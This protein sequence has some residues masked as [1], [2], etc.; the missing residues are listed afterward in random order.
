MTVLIGL[1][2]IIE[3]DVYKGH[4]RYVLSPLGNQVIQEL[5]ESYNNTLYSFC[6]QYG[7]IL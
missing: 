6:D 7:I 2:Y 1:K 4:Q 5:N 3:Y